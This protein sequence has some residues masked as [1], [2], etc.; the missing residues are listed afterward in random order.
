MSD[1]D[2]DDFGNEETK[3]PSAPHCDHCPE[4]DECGK[5]FRWFH[6][7]NAHIQ[8]TKCGAA[9][10]Y[11]GDDTEGKTLA[12]AHSCGCTPCIE[13]LASILGGEFSKATLKRET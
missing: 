5:I 9:I 4:C 11:W 8:G 7:A 3:D 13:S 6:E 10:L 2:L 12:I 1:F